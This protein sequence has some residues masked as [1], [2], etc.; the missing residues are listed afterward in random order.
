[1]DKKEAKKLLVEH[2]KALNTLLNNEGVSETNVDA[3]GTL[4]SIEEREEHLSFI[5]KMIKKAQ[6][7]PVVETFSNL[8]VA[9]SV[10]VTS[11]AVTQTEIA[12]D[13]TETF[14]AE[15]ANDVVERRVEVPQFVDNFV[16]FDNINT[17]GEIVIARKFIE[18]QS[19]A[20]NVSSEI[21]SKIESGE[22]QVSEPQQTSQS[23]G[24][25]SDT[26]PE[27]SAS[28]NSSSSEKSS[29]TD[30][31]SQTEQ[32]S[33]SQQ[34]E[35]ESKEDSSSKESK[36]SEQEKGKSDKQ[37]Q[38]Q[39]QKAEEQ[40]ESQEKSSSETSTQSEEV[41]SEPTQQQTTTEIPKVETPID[42]GGSLRQVSPTN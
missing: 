25:T 23:T 8:G 15:V 5:Q 10:A 39:E 11:A 28:S 33:E 24:E 18:A 37:E 2:S 3:E 9:G 12:K 40:K 36:D 16:D 26:T 19:V 17:W 31:P 4:G 41:K 21:Q 35:Q 42:F 38:P 20:A 6:Q 1:M 27:S 22:I 29:R 30:Q 14:V 13:V 7:V 32:S 34:K